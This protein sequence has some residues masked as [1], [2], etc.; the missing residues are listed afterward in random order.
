MYNLYILYI[1]KVES[2]A[3]R[4]DP[5]FPSDKVKGVKK[6][7]LN[8]LKENY[9]ALTKLLKVSLESFATEMYSCGLI[10]ETIKSGAN[11]NDMMSEFQ[12]VTDFIHNG[13]ELVKHCELFL[14]CLAKQGIPHKR[15][16]N[17]IAEK[18]TSNIK[19]K[20]Y[21]NINFDIEG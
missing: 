5:L 20:I 7:V 11:F 13:Q 16:A 19:E 15:A 3:S 21:I 6:I 18:W 12:V 10:S 17:Y 14:Q 9:P 8:V 2:A 1:A 4:E